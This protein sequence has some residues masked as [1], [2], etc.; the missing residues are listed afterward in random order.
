[1]RC[2]GRGVAENQRLIQ[3]HGQAV[4]LVKFMEL[5]FQHDVDAPLDHPDLLLHDA[6]PP[7]R[8]V[9]HPRA[10]REV[11]FDQLDGRRPVGRR[12]VA[13]H[14]PGLGV[15]PLGLLRA[16]HQRLGGHPLAL[17]AEQAGQRDAE[18]GSQFVQ[19]G[20]RRAGRAA[21]DQGNHGP[22]HAAAR[23][24]RVERVASRR[25]QFAY[26]ASDALV[27]TRIGVVTGGRCGFLHDGFI[28]Q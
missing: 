24:E 18:P 16:P 9:G 11:H 17:A 6:L 21:L 23:G 19:H 14:I 22:A 1:M 12:E 25:P 15:A 7:A 28:I 26:A 10:G 13:P 8:L 4:A 2:P 20:R 5:V 27:D 3:P